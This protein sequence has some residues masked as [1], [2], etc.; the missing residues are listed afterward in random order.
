MQPAVEE[1]DRMLDW[2]DD[3]SLVV[4]GTD[5]TLAPTQMQGAKAATEAGAMLLRKPRWMVER[6]AALQSE[7]ESPN[8]FELG[9]YDGGSTALLSLMLRPRRM[10]SVDLTVTQEFGSEP[11]DL[12]IDDASHLFDETVASFNVLFPRLRPGGLFVLEDWSWQIGRDEAVRAKVESDPKARA[13]LER[14]LAAGD[15]TTWQNPLSLLVLQLVLTA[16]YSESAVAEVM[17]VRKG[18]M[19]IRRG[20]ADLDPATFDI[21]QAFGTAEVTLGSRPLPPAAS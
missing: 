2:R 4:G 14:R 9:I 18:W 5:F 17:S 19:L 7:F 8:V 1:D 16:G 12:V 6:Y 21:T 20:D 13:E 3:V 11:L 10:V 15:V